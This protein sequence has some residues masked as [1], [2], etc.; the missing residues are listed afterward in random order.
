M[1]L[2]FAAVPA[3]AQS[4]VVPADALD[5]MIADA[6]MEGRIAHVNGPRIMHLGADADML[7][8]GPASRLVVALSALR[9]AEQGLLD[10]DAPVKR[11]YPGLH[12]RFLFEHWPTA[13]QLMAETGGFAVPPYI[14]RTTSLAPYLQRSDPPGIWPRDDAA[15]WALLVAI[16]ETA[17]GKPFG[18]I[19]RDEVLMP[20]GLTAADWQA[21]KG[22]QAQLAALSAKGSNRLVATLA[23]LMTRNRDAAGGRYLSPDMFDALTIRLAWETPLT[24]DGRTGGLMLRHWQGRRY[25]TSLPGCGVTFAAFPDADLTLIFKPVTPCTRETDISGFTTMVATSFVPPTPDV[26]FADPLLPT[27]LQPVDGLFRARPDAPSPSLQA[28]FRQVLAPTI[29]LHA[30]LEG[31]GYLKVDK[32]V[33][34]AISSKDGW[35][36]ET[37]NGRV[38]VLDPAAPFDR[39]ILDGKL[40]ERVAPTA[41]PRYALRPI[42]FL[43]PILISGAAFLRVAEHGGWRFTGGLSIATILLVGAGT[44]GELYLWAPALYDLDMPWLIAAARVVLFTGLLAAMGLTLMMLALLKDPAPP[45]NLLTRF[46][47]L[48]LGLAGLAT[49]ILAGI[50][51]LASSFSAT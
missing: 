47:L 34:V 17:A 38:L 9:L 29:G 30:P 35:R 40:Y 50:W 33:R 21:G 20:F 4:V 1:A 28:R 23:R 7:D 24:R 12:D 49:V 6:D 42:A 5:A 19:V 10:L 39:F 22:P 36:W 3:W 25:L 43:L 44:L 15:G 18:D 41:D 37:G 48:V 26:T 13:R 32:D 11:L 27:R 45:R 31:E 2:A 8:L 14:G 51:G 46:H 16:L